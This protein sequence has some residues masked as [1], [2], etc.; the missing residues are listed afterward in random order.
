MFKCT[1]CG[2]EYP[3]KYYFI[4]NSICKDCF[5]KLGE[6]EKQKFLASFDNF[7]AEEVSDLYL[8]NQ[9]YIFIA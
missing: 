6:D 3:S 4:A 2:T 1:K 7:S 8:D 5:C 9:K